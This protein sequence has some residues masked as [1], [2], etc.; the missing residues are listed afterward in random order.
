MKARN[1]IKDPDRKQKKITD[2]NTASRR[3]EYNVKSSSNDNA[4]G[5][6]LTKQND[7]S[8]E[9]QEKTKERKLPVHETR[10]FLQQHQQQQQ[11]QR[12]RQNAAADICEARETRVRG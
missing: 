12:Y 8:R 6:Q 9:M 1:K 3:I 7:T 11:Q 2:H 4:K 10:A 5:L